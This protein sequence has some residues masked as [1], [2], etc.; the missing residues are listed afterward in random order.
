VVK[1]TEQPAITSELRAL[2]E[3]VETLKKRLDEQ[4]K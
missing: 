3:E 2:R 4:K 1:N